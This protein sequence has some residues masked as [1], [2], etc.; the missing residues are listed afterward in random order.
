M[1]ELADMTVSNQQGGITSDGVAADN[2]RIGRGNGNYQKQ[3]ADCLLQT[4][5][6]A[7]AIRACQAL[8]WD[9]VVRYLMS[10]EKHA[11]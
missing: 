6:P 1:R 9:G 2:D 7:A 3:L 8:G 4:L 11:A 10:Q 5:G